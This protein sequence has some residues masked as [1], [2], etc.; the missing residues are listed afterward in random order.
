MRLKYYNFLYFWKKLFQLRGEINIF[1]FFAKYYSASRVRLE[2]YNFLFFS[3]KLFRL[4]G[5]IKIFWLF[6]QIVILLNRWNQD[7]F[8]CK[9]L[10]FLLKYYNFLYFW[11]KLFRLTVEIKIFLF[12]YFFEKGIP[13]YGWYW[14][15]ISF[16]FFAK[17]HSA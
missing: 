15:I 17:S 9:N 1:W 10:F 11:K 5:E 7:I 8:L 2:Y 13:L 4:T 3:E 16:S 14:N 12:F 6:L